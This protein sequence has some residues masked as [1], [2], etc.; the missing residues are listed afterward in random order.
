MS[1]FGYGV[2]I[3]NES[4]YGASADGQYLRLSL[5]RAGTSPDPEQDQGMH[6]TREAWQNLSL[7][8]KT[9]VLLGSS[10][11]RGPFYP[12]RRS[13]GGTVLQLARAW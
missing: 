3:I 10:S 13:G 1:E 11:A 6:I 5:L 2:A 7:H 12:I 4:K 9:H 8:R